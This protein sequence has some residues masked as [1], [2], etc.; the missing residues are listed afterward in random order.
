MFWPRGRFIEWTYPGCR[1]YL[2]GKTDSC[3][4]T[5]PVHSMRVLVEPTMLAGIASGRKPRG[6]LGTWRPCWQPLCSCPPRPAR[7][8]TFLLLPAYT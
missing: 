2:I 3:E 4:K 8:T 6:Y 5:L 7:R 1:L